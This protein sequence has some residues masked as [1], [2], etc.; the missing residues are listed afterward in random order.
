VKAKYGILNEDTYNFD[1]TRFQIGVGGSVKVATAAEIRLNPIGR[2]PGDRE[3]I[4]LIAGVSAGSWL[5]PP[6]FIFKGKNHNQSWYHDN[7]K[8]WRIAV[9]DN[10][11][12]TNKVSVAWLQHFIE[13]TT[14]R[15]VGGYR[16]L[17]LD[18]QESHNSIRFQDICRENNIITLCM[19]AR[20]SHI[21]QPL[22]VGCFSPLN[23]AYKK[24]I[25]AL[26]NSHINHI[27]KLAFLAAFLAV[28][29]G[30]FSSDN[31][32]AGFRATGLVPLAPEV[33]I[34][35]L[36]IKPRTPSPPLPTTPWQPKTPG[37]ALEIEAQSTLIIN[38]IQN[39]ASSSP[40][41][42]VGLM[43]QFY[44]GVEIVM[45]S[46][47]LIA[48]QNEQLQ[49]A[50]AAST[51]RNSRKRKRI[52]KGGTL[53]QEE[54]ANLIARRDALAAAKVVRHEEGRAGGGAPRWIQGC[55]LCGQP[56]HNRRT[57]T[58]DTATL[59]E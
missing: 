52:Q 33:V 38:R 34:S 24:E 25:G 50:N 14:Q 49:A 55:K 53:S 51:E 57:C 21:L 17:I 45:H 37:N 43:Q 47:T 31:I 27:D 32:K 30:V 12:T 1:E 6:F 18:G 48:Q 36:E 8:D 16:L 7:P 11:W 59:A 10:G 46:A 35:K 44:R 3:W 23:R 9:S 2:Q 19:P 58:I 42:L 5:I 26:A 56:G 4:T 41:P 22:D 15:T 13:H 28:Y 40:T 54:A 29:Q 20:A 39:H